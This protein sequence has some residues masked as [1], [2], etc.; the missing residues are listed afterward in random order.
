MAFKHIYLIRCSETVPTDG[1][2]VRLLRTGQMFSLFA[3]E[4][5][6]TWLVS[7]FNHF[8][9]RQRFGRTTQRELDAGTIV[10]VRTPGYGGNISLRRLY[11]HFVFGLKSALWLLRRVKQ[12]HLLVISMPT[13]SAAFFSVLVARLKGA[14][15]VVEV[16]DKWPDVFWYGCS[17][18]RRRLVQAACLPLGAMVGW[19]LRSAMLVAAPSD[20]YRQWTM[21][22]FGVAAESAI[23]SP[24]GYRRSS[25][26]A[27]T[28]PAQSFCRDLAG[29]ARGRRIV[30]FFGTVGRMFDIGTVIDYAVGGQDGLPERERFYFVFLGGGDYLRHWRG[31]VAGSP[32]AEFAG[33]AGK[34]VLDAVAAMSSVALAPY[35]NTP[36]FEGHVPNKIMEYLSYGLPI[37]TCMKG[38]VRRMVEENRL[39][40]YYEE[41]DA[42]GFGAAVR[43]A[44]ALDDGAA[45]RARDYFQ[46]HFDAET[47]YRRLLDEAGSRRD[48]MLRAR[49]SV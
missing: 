13:M 4:Y 40:A 44:A 7:T 45:R 32:Y 1:E 3:R 14:A 33:W 27:P 39:G 36:N 28:A 30:C 16:R 46:A 11:D 17:G 20:E 2:N 26:S 5:P 6:C 34:D 25:G 24:L 21:R 29:R 31:R 10:F 8:E 12:D 37:V 22:R 49:Q 23:V 9:K 38:E 19:A 48:A 35:R 15:A 41:G 47:V 42:A 18:W 43:A